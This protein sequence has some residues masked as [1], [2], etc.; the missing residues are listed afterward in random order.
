[1]TGET[2]DFLKYKSLGDLRSLAQKSIQ[3]IE[4]SILEKGVLIYER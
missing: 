1:M 2:Y 4:K 3:N